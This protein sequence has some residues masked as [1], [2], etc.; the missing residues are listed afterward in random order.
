MSVISF[1]AHT[2]TDLLKFFLEQSERSFKPIWLVSLVL[3]QGTEFLKTVCSDLTYIRI[4]AIKRTENYKC[5]GYRETGTLVHC[6][7]E[8]KIVQP[9]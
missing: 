4:A 2:K 3:T 9:L 5:Q 1:G 8:C 6:W 7:W